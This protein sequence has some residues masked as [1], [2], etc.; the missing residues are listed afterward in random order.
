MGTIEHRQLFSHLVDAA[1]TCK[2]LQEVSFHN[3]ENRDPEVMARLLDLHPCLKSISFRC[4]TSQS[5]QSLCSSMSTNFHLETLKIQLGW[6]T[7]AEYPTYCC[8]LSNLLALFPRLKSIAFL[9]GHE[10]HYTADTS[11]EILLV[12]AV[13]NHEALTDMCWERKI[14]GLVYWN[15]NL[16][17]WVAGNSRIHVMRS[18]CVEHLLCYFRMKSLD[19]HKDIQSVPLADMLHVFSG[20]IRTKVG[21]WGSAV[22]DAHR[23]SF[24]HDTLASRSDWYSSLPR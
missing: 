16:G 4:Q 10:H 13:K 23:L 19:E 18:Y 11:K 7:L 22:E 15:Q 9:Y 20:S 1:I 12:N 14:C 24:V 8:L 5:V 21:N 17:E 2:S 6:D 3:C